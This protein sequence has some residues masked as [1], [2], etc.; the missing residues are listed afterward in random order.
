MVENKYL[1]AIE[2]LTL[3][4]E[5]ATL[6]QIEKETDRFFNWILTL[7]VSKIYDKKCNEY[8]FTIYEDYRLEDE[9]FIYFKCENN[10]YI[11]NTGIYDICKVVK[12]IE[13]IF[14][15]NRIVNNCT[16]FVKVN[17]YISGIVIVITLI[18]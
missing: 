7:L 16:I 2:N 9:N 11:S 6:N 14:F 1:N 4:E 12:K 17:N 13:Q 5:D 8:I 3:I 15:N 18:K 10:L